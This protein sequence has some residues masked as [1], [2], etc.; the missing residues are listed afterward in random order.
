[1][2]PASSLPAAYGG[3]QRLDMLDRGELPDAMAQVE[4][5]R[6]TGKRLEYGMGAA[7]QP[8]APGEQEQRVEIALPHPR[9][10]GRTD[11]RSFL[12]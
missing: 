6:A 7:N 1:M 4:D 8:V 3:N 12:P 2:G 5:M 11:S 9:R 10:S